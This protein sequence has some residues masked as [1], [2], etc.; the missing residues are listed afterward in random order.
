LSIE[1][2][3]T[4]GGVA[5]IENLL[6]NP[7]D[8]GG[9]LRLS[10]IAEVRR[11]P[12]ERADQ[13]IYH[14]GERAFTIGVSG[15]ADANIVDV[16][17]GVEDKLAELMVNLPIGVELQPIY[18]QHIVVDES[19]NGFLINLI[20]SLAIVIGVL[21]VFMGWRAGVTVGAVLLLTVLGTLAFMAG[22]DI[23]MQR[24]S[25]GALII[26]MGMLVDNAI[27]VTEGMQVAVQR[28]VNG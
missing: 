20:M 23:T 2:P 3:Q 22:F 11:A 4:I 24:I 6:I 5:S 21:C 28:G 19:I 8:A 10:D 14:N 16:G 12:V 13:Y 25:L 17:E 7:G 1:L 27:V 18:E 9:T 26:A 15:L